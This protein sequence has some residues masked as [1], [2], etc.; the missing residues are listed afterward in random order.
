MPNVTEPATRKLDEILPGFPKLEGI[1]LLTPTQTELF[2]AHREAIKWHAKYNS[3][4]KN[5]IWIGALQAVTI[6]VLIVC[7]I[8]S[9]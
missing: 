5:A 4:R 1:C 8:L 3:L 6:L 9:R 7:V 2:W